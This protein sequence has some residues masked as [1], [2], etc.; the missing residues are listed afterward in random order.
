MAT[1]TTNRVFLELVMEYRAVCGGSSANYGGS[2]TDHGDGSTAGT[3]PSDR[4]AGRGVSRTG[5]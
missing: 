3:E 2:S 5:S 1:S 4:Y